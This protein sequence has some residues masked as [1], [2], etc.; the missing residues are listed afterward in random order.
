MQKLKALCSLPINATLGLFKTLKEV[1]VDVP[2][3]FAVMRNVDLQLT[4]SK[5]LKYLDARIKHSNETDC[6]KK[7][8]KSV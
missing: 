3:P 2:F 1:F 5:Y 7:C 4:R 8:K 6:C